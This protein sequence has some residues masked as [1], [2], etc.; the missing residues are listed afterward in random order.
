MDRG[1]ILIDMISL[2]NIPSSIQGVRKKLAPL[3]EILVGI[4]LK[5]QLKIPFPG[6][7]VHLGYFLAKDY[8][9]ELRYV[10][11]MLYII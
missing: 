8:F 10:S 1:Y 2:E 6:Y 5:I 7:P 9:L 3:I 4:L 11:M